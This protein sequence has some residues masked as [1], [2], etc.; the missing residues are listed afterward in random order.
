MDAAAVFDNAL[1]RANAEKELG[2]KHFASKRYEEALSAYATVL[3]LEQ[4]LDAGQSSADSSAARA[5][6]VEN[7][8]QVILACRLNSAQC[9]L[10]IEDFHSA[11]QHA[12]RVI[13]VDP[14]NPKALFR[15]GQAQVGNGLFTDGIATLRQAV[16]R[17]PE[18]SKARVEKM[19]RIAEA[20]RKTS[21]RKTKLLGKKL[22]ASSDLAVKALE[23]ARKL[24]HRSLVFLELSARPFGTGRVEIELFDDIVP[25]LARNFRELCR[26]FPKPDAPSDEPSKLHFKGFFYCVLPS[27]F[28]PSTLPSD[29]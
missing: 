18:T 22:L 7:L 24:D 13:S 27:Y 17:V 21:K 25:K 15:L 20:K 8:R 14:M 3:E 10:C 29:M 4:I 6:A 5:D 28:T 1:K 19:I 9:A 11:Q 12:E 23:K 26:G 2:N 16:A